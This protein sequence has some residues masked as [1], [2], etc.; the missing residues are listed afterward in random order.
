MWWK[1]A[2]IGHRI[3]HMSHILR[4]DFRVLYISSHGSTTG[5]DSLMRTSANRT[6]KTGC[7]GEEVEW[8]ATGTGG[9][10]T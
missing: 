4:A 1:W 8:Q 6:A 9:Y 10:L 2:P 7:A 3:L 5:L